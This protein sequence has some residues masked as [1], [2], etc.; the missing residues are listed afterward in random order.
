MD[1]YK[2]H[3]NMSE[4]QRLVERAK[5]LGEE[6]FRM[7]EE[8]TYEFD[9]VEQARLQAVQA[10]NDLQQS[11]EVYKFATKHSDQQQ[12]QHLTG[13]SIQMIE[14]SLDTVNLNSHTVQRMLTKE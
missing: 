2:N 4:T 9:Q 8:S 11:A 7:V 6:Y 1:G 3:H 12:Q 14:F 13:T 5:Q 10:V